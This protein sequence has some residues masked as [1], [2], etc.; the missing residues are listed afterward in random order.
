MEYPGADDTQQHIDH[1]AVKDAIY[2]LYQVLPSGEHPEAHQSGEK[3][4]ETIED[5]DTPVRQ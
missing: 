5:K 2:M 3:Q 1:Q 4:D